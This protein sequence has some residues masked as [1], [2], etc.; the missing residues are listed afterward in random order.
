LWGRT[1]H[2]FGW[3]F[4]YQA[5]VGEGHHLVGVRRPTGGA[6]LLDG[7]NLGGRKRGDLARRIGCR[8]ARAAGVASIRFLRRSQAEGPSAIGV[9]YGIC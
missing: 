8:R 2:V 3:P 7:T 5:L 1:A 9:P 4:G 6:V